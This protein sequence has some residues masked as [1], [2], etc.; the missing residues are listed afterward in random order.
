MTEGDRATQGHRPPD[1]AKWRRQQSI[2]RAFDA[3]IA[4]SDRNTGNSL[5]DPDWNLWMIDHSRT[6]QIPRGDTT[7][8]TVNQLPE[9]FWEALR[10]LD[11]EAMRERL[12]TFLEPAQLTALFKRHEALIAHVE[13]LIEVRGR[14]AVLTQ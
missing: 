3:L 4:N 12:Y 11:P 10:T 2:M 6:F 13:G 5:I 1:A 9:S 14:E 8:T 7:F